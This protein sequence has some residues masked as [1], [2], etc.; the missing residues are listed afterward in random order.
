MLGGVNHFR[1]PEDAV[2]SDGAWGYLGTGI[3]EANA[4]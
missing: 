1:K 2:V 4:K 3:P